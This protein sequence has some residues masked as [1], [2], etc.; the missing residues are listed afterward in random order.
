MGVH[1]S[2]GNGTG[3]KMFH[4]SGEFLEFA[5]WYIHYHGIIIEY[6][7]EINFYCST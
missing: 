3:Q 5:N 2:A 1:C 7:L 4:H 6:L